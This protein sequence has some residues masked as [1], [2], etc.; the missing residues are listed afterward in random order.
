MFKIKS[1]I[2]ENSQSDL[3]DQAIIKTAMTTLGY[4]DDSDTGLNP[5]ADRKLFHSVK[6]FQKDNNLKVDGVIKPDGP[7]QKTIKDRIKATPQTFGAFKDFTKNYLDMRQANTIDADKY[8][9]C[10]A[11]YE[12]TSRGWRGNEVAIGLSNNREKFGQL[13]KGDSKKDRQDDQKANKHGRD[14]AQSGNYSSAKAACEIF[15]PKGLND[16]Y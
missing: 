3:D 8:F 9:H 14:A 1:T 5:Y 4:Y 10:K 16:K 12:A 2:A 13:V 6:D 15:R 11:N 7:T